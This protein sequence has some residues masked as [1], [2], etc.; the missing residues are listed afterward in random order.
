[1]L[2]KKVK[3]YARHLHILR[4]IH[5]CKWIAATI[6]RLCPAYEMKKPHKIGVIG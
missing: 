4:I 3:K 5:D 2:T 1:M 6:N